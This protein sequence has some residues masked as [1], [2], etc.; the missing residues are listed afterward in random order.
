MFA[1]DSEAVDLATKR[2][3]NTQ[4]A[5][6]FIASLSQTQNEG[7]RR[8]SPIQKVYNFAVDL[9]T[10][11]HHNQFKRLGGK[12]TSIPGQTR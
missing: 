7:W 2:T 8:A 3:A 10:L 4:S 1:K 5:E 12:I 6:E 11:R 9:R